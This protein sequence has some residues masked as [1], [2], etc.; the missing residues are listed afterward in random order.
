MSTNHEGGVLKPPQLKYFDVASLASPEESSKPPLF[1]AASSQDLSAKERPKQQ[2]LPIGVIQVSYSDKAGSQ[3]VNRGHLTCA[4]FGAV[5]RWRIRAQTSGAGPLSVVLCLSYGGFGTKKELSY[6]L[7]ILERGW[8]VRIG[9]RGV[10]SRHV[11]H[12]ILCCDGDDVRRQRLILV[13]QLHKC[14]SVNSKGKHNIGWRKSLKRSFSR[15]QSRNMLEDDKIWEE[16]AWREG[17]H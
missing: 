15:C 3:N 17:I 10:L 1:F 12:V 9:L 2:Y 11:R 16:I 7:E 6:S 5:R 14:R 13:T 8:K 4:P